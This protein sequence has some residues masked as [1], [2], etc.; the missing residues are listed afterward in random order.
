[1]SIE[2]ITT[3]H[4]NAHEKSWKTLPKDL[5]QNIV[6]GP[7]LY[8]GLKEENEFAGFYLIGQITGLV[9]VYAMLNGGFDGSV[10]QESYPQVAAGL[11]ACS[12]FFALSNIWGIP[13]GALDRAYGCYKTLKEYIYDPLFK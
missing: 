11:F 8:E 5:A 9:G 6:V 7:L 3:K 12:S 13:I 4:S 10:V 2:E 1:M